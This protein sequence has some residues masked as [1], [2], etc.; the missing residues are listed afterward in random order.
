MNSED[1]VPFKQSLSKRGVG[2]CGSF[3]LTRKDVMPPC[4]AGSSGV[5]ISMPGSARAFRT[6]PS[7]RARSRRRA[8]ARSTLCWN[9]SARDGQPGSVIE[10]PGMDTGHDGVETVGV[11]GG[12]TVDPGER[13]FRI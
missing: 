11:F 12:I 6:Q 13:A 3:A 10:R 7:R 1:A 4:K 5:S 8:R 2:L 9:A